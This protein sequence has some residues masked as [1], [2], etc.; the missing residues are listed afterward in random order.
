[1][2][3][4]DDADA[5][6][7]IISSIEKRWAVA[8]QEVFIACLIVNPF[9]QTR[10]FAKLYHFNNSGVSM[11]LGRLWKRFYEAEPSFEFYEEVKEYLN[12]T[13][14]YK[15]LANQC[16]RQQHTAEAKVCLII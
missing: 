5:V 9:Y 13:D 10:P 7:A 11:L 8:D 6:D 4:P 14:R 16:A 1:M 3:D 15:D 2:K 12:H